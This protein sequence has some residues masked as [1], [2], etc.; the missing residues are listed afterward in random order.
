ML[1][2]FPAVQCLES[3]C[4]YQ[5]KGSVPGLGSTKTVPQQ[6]K[7]VSLRAYLCAATTEVQ[8]PGARAR[9]REQPRNVK[10][11]Q[12]HR[13]GEELPLLQLGESSEQRNGDPASEK[14]LDWRMPSHGPQG[15]AEVFLRGRAHLLLPWNFLGFEP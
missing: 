13:R 1:G 4:Q 11:T 5:D 8:A 7:P 12:W 10:P 9:S 3:A 14:K 6:L 2:T 15:D